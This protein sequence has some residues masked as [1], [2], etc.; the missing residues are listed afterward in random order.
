MPGGAKKFDEHYL[1]WRG[2]NPR[3]GRSIVTG[4]RTPRFRKQGGKS[5]GPRLRRRAK[6]KALEVIL[7]EVADFVERASTATLF[8]RGEASTHFAPPSTAACKKKNP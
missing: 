1:W 7:G 4:Q 8:W 3:K 5:A 2:K 6:E